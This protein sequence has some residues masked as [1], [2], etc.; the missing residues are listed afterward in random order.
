VARSGILTAGSKRALDAVARAALSLAAPDAEARVLDVEAGLG[1]LTLL[2]A[3]KV[4]HV[5]AV[6]ASDAIVKALRARVAVAKL[7]NVE[8]RVADP[9]ALPFVERTFDA[10][11]LTS[12]EGARDGVV[13]ELR[14]VLKPGRPAIVAGRDR[15]ALVEELTLAGFDDVE[16]HDVKSA[17]AWLAVGIA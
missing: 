12:V 13:A 16:A 8:A 11:Y 15:D 14:R 1:A 4:A 6:D 7:K 5:T 17:H 9:T 2:V 10:V 3:T